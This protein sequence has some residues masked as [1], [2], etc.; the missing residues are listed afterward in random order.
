MFLTQKTLSKE[1]EDF[2]GTR[3][4]RSHYRTLEA[5]TFHAH[6]FQY[7]VLALSILAGFHIAF[8]NIL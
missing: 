7:G 2:K 3:E 6:L 1:N 4:V 8:V 5:V